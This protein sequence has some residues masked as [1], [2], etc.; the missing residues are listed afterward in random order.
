M[1]KLLSKKIGREFW[2]DP[3]RTEPF[4]GLPC[5]NEEEVAIL[6]AMDAS[7]EELDF[8]FTAKAELGVIL[9][10]VLPKKRPE[11]VLPPEKEVLHQVPQTHE[12]YAKTKR[13]EMVRY[14]AKAVR[15]EI[16]SRKVKT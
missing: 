3:V 14:W 6:K 9:T 15:E 12:A 5:F 10:E 11:A 16:A 7:H 1:K 4:E 13:E 8:I 2:I